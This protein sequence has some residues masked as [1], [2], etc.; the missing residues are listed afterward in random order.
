MAELKKKKT[1]IKSRRPKIKNQGSGPR[2]KASG[3]KV[4]VKKRVYKRGAKKGEIKL[5]RSVRNP[6][7]VPTPYPWESFATFNPAAVVSGGRVHLFYR[8]LGPDGISRIGYASSPDGINF[9][10]RCIY[11]VFAAENVQ[12]WINAS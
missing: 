1:K 7:I 10:Q 2:S 11:P 3:K 8:A 4:V 12:D 5:K 6:I 9:D